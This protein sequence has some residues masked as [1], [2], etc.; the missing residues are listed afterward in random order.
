MITEYFFPTSIS[1][2]YCPFHNEIENNLVNHCFKLSEKISN[3]VKTFNNNDKLYTTYKTHDILLDEK[4]NKLNDWVKE[5]IN[6]YIKQT[7]M[8]INFK[9]KGSSFFNIYK[10]HDY[11]ELHEHS[12]D[13]IS[14]IYFLKCN[15]KSSRVFFKSRMADSIEYTK[16]AP[17]G[18]I[19][20]KP[21]PGKLLVFR[22]NVQHFVEQHLDD[23]ERITL[24][25]NFKG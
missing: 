3:G 17:T 16:N 2:S 25:Y 23:E 9:G 8:I 13:I 7:H 4:F 11:Q 24:A 15:E 10:K 5:Q 14:C 12:G 1:H 21:E 18:N 19:F 20:F 22:S 6:E